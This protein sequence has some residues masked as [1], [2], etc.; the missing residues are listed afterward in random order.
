MIFCESTGYTPDQLTSLTE[1]QIS[2]L[3]QSHIDTLATNGMSKSY[4]NTV[5]KRLKTFFRANGIK[6]ETRS[7]YQPTRYRKRLEYIPTKQEI[8][9]IAD[10]AD[11]Q[12]DRAIILCLWTSGFRIST[13]CAL[14]I[15]DIKEEIDNNEPIIRVPVYPEMKQKVHD[16]C[17]GLV[18]YYSFISKE[19]QTALRVYLNER[20]EYYGIIEPEQP[21]FCSDWNLWPRKTRPLKHIGRR[22]VSVLLKKS[23]RLADIAKWAQIS[24]HCLRK[25]FESVLRSPTTDSSRMDKGTQEF[26]MGHI[27]PGTQDTYYDRTNIDYHREEYAKLDF[28]RTTT[29][30]K[31]VDKLIQLKA[32]ET[33]LN[34]G[35]L[36]VSKISDDT[37]VV[38]RQ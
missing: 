28:T 16:A 35:W 27:L 4:V 24:P 33:H 3:I 37:I 34:E 10:A 7:Y 15:G 1:P 19:A 17:K 25:S 20:E 11:N 29:T 23:A 13:F 36:F 8:Y 12:R 32:L 22:C 5:N 30:P 14:T 18:P 31:A 26:F 9:R 6:P 2:Q 21:L 38:R